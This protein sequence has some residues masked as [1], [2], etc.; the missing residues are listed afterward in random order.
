M[1]EEVLPRSSQL[2]EPAVANVDHVLLVFSAAAP[3]FQSSPATR[4]LLAAEAAWLPVTVA[5]NKA[6][7]LAPGEVQ[8]VVDQARLPVA[9]A[10]GALACRPA[11]TVPSAGPLPHRGI[12]GGALLAPIPASLRSD[13]AG[14]CAPQR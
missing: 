8:A 4:Y 9:A 5:I 11:A 2:S 10:S 3:A 7:L 1:V 6:D 13:D 12:C 14:A